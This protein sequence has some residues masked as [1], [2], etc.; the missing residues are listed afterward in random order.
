MSGARHLDGRLEDLPPSALRDIAHLHRWESVFDHPWEGDQ[1]ESAGDEHAAEETK[2]S[3]APA[4]GNPKGA[5]YAW[6]PVLPADHHSLYR[7][8]LREG[9]RLDPSACSGFLVVDDDLRRAKVIAPAY[10]ALARLKWFVG[11]EDTLR[12]LL[13]EVIRSNDFPV[14]LLPEWEP[15]YRELHQ[16]FHN[17][18]RLLEEAYCPLLSLSR[19]GYVAGEKRYKF[20]RSLTYMASRGVRHDVRDHLCELPIAKPAAN[21]RNIPSCLLPLLLAHGSPPPPST[22]TNVER[23]L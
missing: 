12:E 5:K 20:R 22:T 1:E 15:I 3:A 7:V 16:G 19:E 8:L 11:K 21:Q 2:D 14:F 9:R 23:E 18:L 10:A 13:L 6:P 4:A 17:L